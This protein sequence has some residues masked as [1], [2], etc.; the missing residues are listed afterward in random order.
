MKCKKT[1]VGKKV[2]TRWEAEYDWMESCNFT[3][4]DISTRVMSVRC[5]IQFE[6]IHLI[7][8]RTNCI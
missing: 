4:K 6:G 7:H 1:F 3:M 5:A 8:A 2:K